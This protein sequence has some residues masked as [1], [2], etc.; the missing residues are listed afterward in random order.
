VNR[1]LASI[2]PWLQGYLAGTGFVMLA[3]SANSIVDLPEF[4]YLRGVR[5]PTEGDGARIYDS[6]PSV[7]PVDCR[8]PA[9]VHQAYPD[10]ALHEAG[11]GLRHRLTPA[12]QAEWRATHA[13]AAWP[14]TVEALGEW[15]AFAGAFARWVLA[16]DNP[17]AAD[18][19]FADLAA[20]LSPDC[21]A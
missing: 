6:V 12:A 2:P 7:G 9:V 14:N 18:R 1:V 5:T 15:E 21:P 4:V 3:H 8:T 20:K 17:A 19:Y 16:A 10:T 13:A 11:H